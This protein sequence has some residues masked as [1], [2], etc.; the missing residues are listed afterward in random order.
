VIRA[1]AWDIDG[2][3]V[4]SEPR[5]HRAL[6]AA[7]R[8]LGVAL[9][10]LPDQAFRGVHML[11]VWEVLRPRY[12]SHVGREPWLEAINRAYVA[13]AAPLIPIPGGSEVIQSLH[14][15]GLSQVCVSNSNR[16]V[17]DANIVA[18][19][20]A[21]YL[22][23]SISLDDVSRGKPDPEP[24]L[25]ACAMLGLAPHEVAAVEDSATGAASA[26]R[27]GLFVI[28]FGPDLGDA[29]ADCLCE[30]LFEIPGVLGQARGLHPGSPRAGFRP[31]SDG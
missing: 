26:R 3:L 8:A 2:T 17:V 15:A 7:S 11:D 1:I 12:P 24:Y 13:D 19:G 28:G 23:G 29:G 20:L 4:D 31:A 27:A 9:D 5:H 30:S 18:L 10:D 6:L 25:L 22:V 14:A 16:V 21:P